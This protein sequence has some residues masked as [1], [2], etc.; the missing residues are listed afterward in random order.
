MRNRIEGA[1]PLYIALVIA[2]AA[3]VLITF[4]YKHKSTS[5]FGIA[6]TMEIAVT[7]ENPIEIKRINVVEGQSVIRGQRLVELENP[8]LTIQI[9]DISHELERRKAEYDINKALT[10]GLRSIGNAEDHEESRSSNSHALSVNPLDV[11]TDLDQ[12]PVP[13]SES[14]AEIQVRQLEE[15]LSLMKLEQS[16]LNICA[17]I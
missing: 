1:W 3:V 5:F 10:A 12:R 4:S 16:K 14:P 9:N 13:G 11:E 8:N 17:E 15:K 6:E 7:S 2:F